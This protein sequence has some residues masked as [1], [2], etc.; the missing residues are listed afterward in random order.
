MQRLTLVRYQGWGLDPGPLRRT[1]GPACLIDGSGAER[2]ALLGVSCTCQSLKVSI[3]SSLPL[4]KTYATSA[5]CSSDQKGEFI[6]LET[7]DLVWQ[8][9]SL[10]QTPDSGSGA[11]PPPETKNPVEGAGGDCLSLRVRQVGLEDASS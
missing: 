5:L 2:S 10:P 1:W 3:Y 7:D 4:L 6:H 8:H 9:C 11:A